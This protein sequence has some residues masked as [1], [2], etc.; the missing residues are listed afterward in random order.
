MK[1]FLISKDFRL[2]IKGEKLKKLLKISLKEWIKY[3]KY[4]ENLK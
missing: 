2:N 4:L 3:Q 1:S